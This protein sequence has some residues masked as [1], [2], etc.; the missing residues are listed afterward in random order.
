MMTLFHP[1]F[2]NKAMTDLEILDDGGSVRANVKYVCGISDNFV[3]EHFYTTKK[4]NDSN[5]L[6]TFRINC[7]RNLGKKRT[8][9]KKII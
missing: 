7:V 1:N 3:S 2:S 5:F 6:E 4:K 8:R 9:K